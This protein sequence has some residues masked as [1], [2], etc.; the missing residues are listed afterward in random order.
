MGRGKNSVL[1][2]GSTPQ[3]QS[4]KRNTSSNKDKISQP[5]DLEK[6]RN[7]SV[8]GLASTRKK[9]FER[10]NGIKQEEEGVRL[11]ST[12]QLKQSVSFSD[13][14]LH[15]QMSTPDQN[16]LSKG[17]NLNSYSETKK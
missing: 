17:P 14:N 5:N 13:R 9:L 10:E 4:L 1:N 6:P 12:P 2:K 7:A 11:Q 16:A 8:R 15:F 3:S